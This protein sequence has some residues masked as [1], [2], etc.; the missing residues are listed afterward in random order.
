MTYAASAVSYW[1]GQANDSSTGTHPPGWASGQRWSAT[2]NSWMNVYNTEYANARDNSAGQPGKP[3]GIQ[4]P[5]GW[6]AGQLWSATAT[7]WNTMWGTEWTNA[8]DN[9]GGQTS[10]GLGAAHP[11]N[12]VAG[13]MWSATA[14]QWNAMWGNEWRNSHD[15]QGYSY[16]Y[17]GQ[18]A[19]AVYWSQS[20]S[21]WRGQADYYW[22][23]SRVWNNGATW[24][25]NYNAYVGYYNDMVNQRDT[26]S[27]R[28]NQAWGPSRVWSNG[29]S[30]EAAYNRVLPPGG[31]VQ[32]NGTNTATSFPDG[33]NMT[34]LSYI[35][36]DRA[37]YWAFSYS[38]KVSSTSD[39]LNL[40]ARYAG[41]ARF[42]DIWSPGNA[43]S[44]AAGLGGIYTLGAGQLLEIW[45]VHGY[46]GGYNISAQTLQ[47]WFVPMTSYPH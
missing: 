28:A 4:H 35:T 11:T 23:P 25:Q 44:F 36:A 47:C 14:D 10:S 42:S 12:W 40:E 41:T 29:E 33:V 32:I 34:R 15:P 39:R 26:W 18:G 19:N 2:A 30:W 37:G 17:P 45:G 46:N 20:A 16:S 38:L 21:Y 1:V 3:G 8:R 6:V 31:I 5:T 24:E 43:G 9:S 27:S 7:Q 13:Q 22:G